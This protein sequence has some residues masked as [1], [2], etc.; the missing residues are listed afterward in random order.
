M[1]SANVHCQLHFT[2]CI[3]LNHMC[4]SESKVLYMKALSYDFIEKILNKSASH[5]DGKNAW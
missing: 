2:H 1:S 4:N 3:S 5:D